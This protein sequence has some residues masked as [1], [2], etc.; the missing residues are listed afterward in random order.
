MLAAAAHNRS[1]ELADHQRGRFLEIEGT[2]PVTPGKLYPVIG[3]GIWETVLHALI[4]DDDGLANWCPI[5]LFD[6]GPQTLPSEW[7]FALAD[8][9]SASGRQLWT[10]WVARWGYDELVKDVDHSD[11]LM[12]RDPE[13]IRIFQR[14]VDRAWN[15]NR[16]EEDG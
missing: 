2:Y 8:G 13:A 11:A 7:S 4:E 9:V 16:S 3:L 14:E 10:R 12:N 6:I 5:G 15:R 1:S